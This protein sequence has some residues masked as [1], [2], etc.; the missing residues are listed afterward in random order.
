MTNPILRLTDVSKSF[1]V[2]AE[3]GRG[4]PGSRRDRIHAVQ[5]VSLE[6]SEGEA[7]GIVGE[8]GCGKSTLAKL[9]V[10]LLT[11]DSGQVLYR[12]RDL[13]TVGARDL[14]HIQMVF[15]NPYGSLNPRLTIGS[16]IGEPLRVYRLV[17]RGSV[18]A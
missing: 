6:V 1:A 18:S 13:E 7:L 16:A 12:E 14:R 10:R 5:Q 17:D 8:S 4:M 15:Q 11:P 2:R 3:R 9:L